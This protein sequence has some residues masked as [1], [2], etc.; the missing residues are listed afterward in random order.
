MSVIGQTVDTRFIGGPMDQR[1]MQVARTT[2]ESESLIHVR[3]S[4]DTV[5]SYK[6]Y[7][8]LDTGWEMHLT[9]ATRSDNCAKT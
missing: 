4:D 6:P 1:V 7:F 2:L 3:E 5:I 8:S 9:T